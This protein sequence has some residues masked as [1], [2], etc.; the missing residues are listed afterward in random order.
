MKSILIAFGFCLIC[1]LNYTALAQENNK[2]VK[3]FVRSFEDKVFIQNYGQFNGKNGSDE[4]QIVYGINN[5]GTQ[6]YFTQTGLIYRYDFVEFP[7]SEMNPSA[8]VSGPMEDKREELMR[9]AKHLN[10]ILNMKWIGANED[11]QL[12]AEEKVSQYYNYQTEAV[13]GSIDFVPAFKKLCYKNLYPGIDV[14]YVFPENKEG[15][16]Y[17]FIIHPGADVGKIQMQYSGG[18]EILK[19]ENGNVQITTAKGNI[20]D[21]APV[22]FYTDNKSKI[23]SSFDLRENSV[24]L[25]VGNYDKSRSIVIDPWTIS[26]DF[27]TLNRGY[28]IDVD[29]TGNIYVMGGGAGTPGS[30]GYMLKKFSSSGTLIWTYIPPTLFG[31][32]GDFEL[33]S[34]GNS[35]IVNG[36]GGDLIKLSP[37][38][39]L[40]YD[41]FI[42]EFG[43]PW[44]LKLNNSNNRIYGGGY[45]S[46]GGIY[47]GL[48]EINNTGTAATSKGSQ[49][50]GNV[51]NSKEIRSVEIDESNGDIYALSVSQYGSISASTNNLIKL[52]ASLVT[53]YDIQSG[54]LEAE[55]GVAYTNDPGTAGQSGFNGFNGIVVDPYSNQ[56]FTYDGLTII[57]RNKVNGDLIDTVIVSNTSYDSNSG[58]CIDSCSNV[59]VGTQNTIAKYDSSL[60]FIASISTPGSVYDICKFSNN[61]IVACGDGF[62]GLFSID[63]ECGDKPTI[64][65]PPAPLVLNIPNVFT[66]N[67]DGVNETFKITAEGYSSYHI[68]IFNRWGQLLFESTETN[69]HWNGKVRQSNKEAP[70]GTYYYVI[71]VSVKEETE[72]HKGF[73]T[74]L[75]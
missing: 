75:R 51:V 38:G 41:N 49:M 5:L 4:K 69:N 16:K 52:D 64:N 12:V 25:N 74:L 67:G 11:V 37:A 63:Y 58:I 62:V 7:P 73:L 46:A 20:I 56:L 22:T 28:D 45:F 17:T 59:Y 29:K 23:I 43:E 34:F 32:Y 3:G 19:D 21:H 6:I 9:E 72:S 31:W 68:K 53:I 15:I 40:I 70:D 60:K 1:Q 48:V 33:D 24:R 61:S 27:T 10:C 54:F 57:K 18:K 13:N 71:E 30:A 35:Y 44:R 2:A 26:T 55:E 8:D 36:T 65:I 66:P 39:S 50:P 47:Y 42:T 14:E